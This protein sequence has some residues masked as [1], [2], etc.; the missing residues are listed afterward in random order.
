MMTKFIYIHGVERQNILKT[1]FTN[2]NVLKKIINILYIKN[3][4]IEKY[5]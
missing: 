1:F 4:C 3:K 5:D 2:N